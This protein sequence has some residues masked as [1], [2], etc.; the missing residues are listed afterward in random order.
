MA[1]SYR[2]GMKAF[3]LGLVILASVGCSKKKDGAGS[4][5]SGGSGS[6]AAASGGSAV[7][8][9]QPIDDVSCDVASKAYAKK[10]AATPGNVLSDAKPDDG[11]LYYTA[12]SMED[13]CVGED[14]AVVAW[15][16]AERA[17]VNAAA[18]TS[19]AVTACFSGASLSQVNAGLTEVVTTALANKKANEANKAGA[20]DGSAES[21]GG[22]GSP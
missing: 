14:G 5:G 3:V 6:A 18:E 16:A 20:D 13:Y 15:T 10:M 1:I 8:P 12:I 17:C 2:R 22:S 7:A 4:A 21:G 19:A 9:S 11:L